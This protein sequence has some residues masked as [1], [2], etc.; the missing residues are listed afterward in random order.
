MREIEA[1]K[2]SYANKGF[3]SEEPMALFGE[4]FQPVLMMSQAPGGFIVFGLVLAVVNT[5]DAHNRKKKE[6]VA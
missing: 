5:I 1:L 2:H 3:E 4:N 6:S